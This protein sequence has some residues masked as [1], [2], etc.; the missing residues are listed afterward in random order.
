MNQF[1]NALRTLHTVD[2]LYTTQAINH[3]SHI[4]IS[5]RQANNMHF[6]HFPYLR[7]LPNST[8][9]LTPINVSIQGAYGPNHVGGPVVWFGIKYKLPKCRMLFTQSQQHSV[10]CT[11]QQ[12]NLDDGQLHYC[13]FPICDLSPIMCKCVYMNACCMFLFTLND[14]TCGTKS[15]YYTIR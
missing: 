7:I 2:T 11:L 13:M 4:Q 3:I 9:H 5:V 10:R 14:S 15:E 8:F 12:T 6:P 1:W